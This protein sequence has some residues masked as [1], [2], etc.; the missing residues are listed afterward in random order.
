M[1]FSQ[2]R[3]LSEALALQ[4]THHNRIV[5][6]SHSCDAGQPISSLQIPDVIIHPVNPATLTS[7]RHKAKSGGGHMKVGHSGSADG[8]LAV[9]PSHMTRYSR[10]RSREA[11]QQTAS[12]IPCHHDL[13]P[14]QGQM[15]TLCVP[16]VDYS[17][18]RESYP[19]SSGPAIISALSPP[20]GLAGQYPDIQP[21]G[22]DVAYRHNNQQPHDL[23]SPRTVH[24]RQT[25]STQR[26]LGVGVQHGSH[27]TF[28]QRDKWHEWQHL[29]ADSHEPQTL[30]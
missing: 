11:D 4:H 16:S 7:P 8:Q 21:G 2:P 13:Q 28:D 14:S 9:P 6:R 30:V 23:S 1:V 20:S 15:S 29:S 17:L 25:S 3:T 5:L 18:L 19:D 22:N 10:S 24:A 27:R 12:S 26:P